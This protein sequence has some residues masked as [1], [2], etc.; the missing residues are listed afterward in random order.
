FCEQGGKV[1][2][3]KQRQWISIIVGLAAIVYGIL[4]LGKPYFSLENVPVL[5]LFTSLFL[6]IWR[7]PWSQRAMIGAV[8]LTVAF[9]ALIS[10]ELSIALLVYGVIAWL[11]AR[12]LLG[13]IIA[14][15]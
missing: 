6:L 14:R 3:S 12:G 15:R 9:G 11:L 13:L 8:V 5:L 2:T 7:G 4:V 10:E 1:V